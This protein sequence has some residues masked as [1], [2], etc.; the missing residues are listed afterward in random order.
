MQPSRCVAQNAYV[1]PDLDAAL[2]HWVERRAVGPFFVFERMVFADH[3]YRGTPSQPT[4]SVALAYSGAMQVELIAQ[5][6]EQP[7]VYREF[8]AAGGRGLHHVGFGAGDIEAESAAYQAGGY[9]RALD[10]R[11]AGGTRVVYFDTV[12]ELGH[13]TELWEETAELTPLFQ[14]IEDA[15][16]D[17]DGRDPIRRLQA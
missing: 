6:D 3:R 1:V 15:A 14:M 10:G 16:R 17:W 5:H 8:L 9:V 7:S 11:L 13:F 2:R 12:A 4:L